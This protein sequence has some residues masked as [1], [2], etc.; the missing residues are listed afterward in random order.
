MGAKERAL[1][2]LRAT[3][4]AG[5]PRRADLR[6]SL[7]DL[8]WDATQ[9]PRVRGWALETL[10]QETRGAEE[11]AALATELG[12]LVAREADPA[13]IATC[14]AWARSGGRVEMFPGLVRAAANNAMARGESLEAIRALAVQR[15]PAR[16]AAEAVFALVL[17]PQVPAAQRSSTIDFARRL[18]N[19]AW[20][21]LALL[22]PTGQERAALVAG[23][24]PAGESAQRLV[25]AL[26]TTAAS[27]RVLPQTGDE[28]EW[29]LAWH[30]GDGAR[31]REATGIVA[32][33][34]AQTTGMLGMRHIEPLRWAA[35]QRPAWLRASRE[36]LLAELRGRLASRDR[37]VRPWKAAVKPYSEALEG[38]E[39][40][41]AWADVLSILVL[42]DVVR[43]AGVVAG[44]LRQAE[45]DRADRSTEYGGLVMV[46][47]R[48]SPRAEP[49]LYPPRA[50]Q[51]RSDMEFTASEEMLADSRSRAG[52]LA[53]YHLH[54]LAQNNSEASGPSE[55]DLAYAE[56]F[57]AA[58]LVFTTLG[59]DLV[60][61]DY[62]QPRAGGGAVVLDLGLVRGEQAAAQR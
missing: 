5:E 39:G 38:Q 17:D 51:R 7:L 36:E 11:A 10:M 8:V 27:L 47:L 4:G 55:G 45:L 31:V 23:A 37:A 26:R 29:L 24:S 12:G 30:A 18:R 9:P 48:G 6:A 46:G 25:D 57:A 34:D 1:A 14:A 40:G 53:H 2:D 3:P 60:N 22:D 43:E 58:C 28:L 61:V 50:A 42:D 62:Y 59:T 52:V 20:T 19:D 15:P 13:I 32:Q 21:T 16:S 35:A 49:L 54:A 41:L 44:V 33:L 56:R